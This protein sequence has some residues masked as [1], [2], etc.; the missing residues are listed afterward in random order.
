MSV[1]G[2]GGFSVFV[3]FFAR[4]TQH[5][6]QSNKSKTAQTMHNHLAQPD[7]T[8]ANKVEGIRGS[9]WSSACPFVVSGL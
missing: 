9:L 2:L 3:L 6:P 5:E 7:E 8:Q 1:H 4:T